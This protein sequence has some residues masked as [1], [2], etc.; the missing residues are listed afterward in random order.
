MKVI[1]V[2]WVNQYHLYEYFWIFGTKYLSFHN[3]LRE[4]ALNASA[5]DTC[6]FPERIMLA[7]FKVWSNSQISHQ[8]VVDFQEPS[9]TV[10]LYNKSVP[11]R[12]RI[13]R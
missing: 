1:M 10:R 2:F 13:K 7:K 9:K 8:G 6:T 4:F 12:K 3:Y 11:N 5:M